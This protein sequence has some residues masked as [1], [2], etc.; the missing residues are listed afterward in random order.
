M[1]GKKSSMKK[2]KKRIDILLS[3]EDKFE[4]NFNVDKKLDFGTPKS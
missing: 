3:S 2:I 4:N 1:E